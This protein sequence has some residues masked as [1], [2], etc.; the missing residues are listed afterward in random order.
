[1]WFIHSNSVSLRIHEFRP[2]LVMF[3]TFTL[4]FW[5][6]LLRWATPSE[7]V[8][9]PLCQSS[10]LRPVTCPPTFPPTSF[11]SPTDRS[12]MLKHEPTYSPLET[13]LS[14]SIWKAPRCHV[15]DVI[16]F[17]PSFAIVLC[18]S[19]W[20]KEFWIIRNFLFFRFLLLAGPFLMNLTFSIRFCPFADFLGDWVVLQRYPTCH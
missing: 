9:S 18:F 17:L 2:T 4:V 20:L 7:A 19:N 12:A 14:C 16:L 10:R 15:W 8:P 5:S 11:L 6:V 1:M 3:S 13:C